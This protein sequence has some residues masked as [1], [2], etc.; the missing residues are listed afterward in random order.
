[1]E[2]GGNCMNGRLFWGFILILLGVGLLLDQT[3]YIN[4]GDIISLYWPCILILIGIFGLFDRKSSKVWNSVLV[5]FG[6][7][8]QMRRL[9]YID[10]DIFRLLFPIILIVVGISI[11]F[12][13]GVKKNNNFADSEKRGRSNIS[14]EDTV[15]LF[16]IFSA[17]DTL[18]QS[19][20]FKG[21]KISAIFGGIDLDLRKAKLNNNEAFMDVTALFGGVDILVPDDWRVEMMGTPILGGWDNNTK[22]NLDPNA[23]VLKI[24]GT[25]IFGGIEVK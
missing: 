2:R 25:P 12:N 7:L 22:P 15:D 13:Y 11:I 24:R 23:P 9:D 8:M 1:M 18:N 16:V 21:G 14:M 17:I 19:Q 4:F 5:I 10:V 20:T 6:V 3:G